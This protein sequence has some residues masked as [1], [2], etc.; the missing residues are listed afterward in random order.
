MH[1]ERKVI[2]SSPS[3]PPH[4]GA[5]KRLYEWFAEAVETLRETDPTGW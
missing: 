1:F 3:E 5:G 2:E 4:G